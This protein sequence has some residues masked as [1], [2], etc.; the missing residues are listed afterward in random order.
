MKTFSGDQKVTE[1]LQ[2]NVNYM[3]AVTFGVQTSWQPGANF[4]KVASVQY[5]NWWSA[6]IVDNDN[7]I[8]F[9]CENKGTSATNGQRS[10][11]G[12]TSFLD[13][14]NAK[15]TTSVNALSGAAPAQNVQGE[16]ASL[17]KLDGAVSKN[18]GFYI[19]G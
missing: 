3:W 7:W 6:K 9:T 10:D 18:I 4:S 1:L 13:Q 8:H 14:A 5:S 11:N 2:G 16:L 19:P 12:A 15:L 17:L